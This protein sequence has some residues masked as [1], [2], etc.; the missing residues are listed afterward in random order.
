[1]YLVWSHGHAT[2]CCPGCRGA[3]TECRHRTKSA[4]VSSVFHTNV[5]ERVMICMETAT[6]SESVIWTPNLGS[7]ASSGPMQNAI[8][9]MVRPAIAPRNSSVITVFM[10]MGSIQLL[11]GPASEESW[12]QMKVRSSTRATSSGSDVHQKELGFFDSATKVPL[13]TRSVVSLRHSRSEPSHQTTVSG[14][15]RSATVWTQSMTAL[16]V[17]GALSRPVM[18]AVVMM[19]VLGDVGIGGWLR[20]CAIGAGTGDAGDGRLGGW[21]FSRGGTPLIGAVRVE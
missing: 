17:V 11:V 13:S 6:Y 21:C 18:L 16:A 12:E 7:A 5:P 3:P 9:Y 19:I 2:S 1:M 14:V 8:T 20:V 4:P 10:S 15:V